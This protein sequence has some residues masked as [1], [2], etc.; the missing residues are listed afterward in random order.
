MNV[1]QI[2]N[3]GWT[4]FTSE[5]KD[6]KKLLEI[7]SKY[8]LPFSD[9]NGKLVQTLESK[10]EKS[11]IRKSFSYNYGLSNF[12]Y[13]TD[14]SFNDIPARYFLLSSVF[15][16]N[17]T[18]NIV[19]FYSIFKRLKDE[20]IKIM[21]NAIFLL[22]TPQEAKFTKMLFKQNNLLGIRFDPNIMTPYNLNAK[23]SVIILE[24]YLKEIKPIEIDWTKQNILLVDNWRCLHSRSKVIDKKRTLKRIYIK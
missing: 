7:A 22:K 21:E 16:S 23:E 14:T 10:P 1:E 5:K 6:D 20:E 2:V 24:R 8:G 17:T 13:H 11:G 15:K 3:D 9:S 4:L 19:D 18:T 12:P